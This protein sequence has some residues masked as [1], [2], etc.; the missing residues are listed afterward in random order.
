MNLSKIIGNLFGRGLRRKNRLQRIRMMRE[1]KAYQRRVQDAER[2]QKVLKWP[3]VQMTG[4]QFAALKSQK[5]DLQT[6]PLGTWFVYK[7]PLPYLPGVTIIGQVVK[8]LDM[9]CD[10]WGAG[11]SVPD[12]GA[13]KY[14]LEII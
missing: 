14:R 11:L 7:K 13:R 5:I 9:F 10:Q 4:E 2:R 8:G 6:C 12:R 3:Q 1:E